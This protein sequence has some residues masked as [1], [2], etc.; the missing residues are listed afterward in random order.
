MKIIAEIGINYNTDFKKIEEMIRQCAYGGADFAKFQLYSS[1]RVFGD[2]SRKCN[3][4]SFKQTKEISEICNFHGIEFFAS[5]FDSERLNWCEEIGVKTYKIASRTLIKEPDLCNE[6]ISTKK[7]TF[8]SLGMWPNYEND[9]S[10]KILPFNFEDYSN[11]IYLHCISKYPTKCHDLKI[12]KY[13][14][15]VCGLSDHT[16]GIAYPLYNINLGAQVVEKHFTLSK[17]MDGNDHIGSMDLA[18]LINLKKIGT[19]LYNISKSLK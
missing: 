10:V 9:G 7:P 18:D 4:L 13:D 1:Q 19:E 17:S 5:V 14:E 16:Y 6:I 3:E 12:F 11:I 8:I 2:D 15:N